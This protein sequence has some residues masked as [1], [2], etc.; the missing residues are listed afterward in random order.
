MSRKIA[1]S[2][3]DA[4]TIDI[5]NVI[6]S[7]S[8]LEY[9]TSVPA[10]TTLKDVPEVGMKI[11]G[12]PAFAN[13]YVNAL[14][15]RIAGVIVRSATFNDPFKLLKKGIIRYGETIEEV[16]VEMAKAREF[17]PEKA[18]QRELARVLPDIKAAFHVI[19][20]DVEIPMSIQNDDL[21]RA[22]TTEDGVLELIAKITDSIYRKVEY[23]EYNLFKYLLIKGYNNNEIYKYTIGSGLGVD[24]NHDA[25]IAFRALANRLTFITDKYNEAGVHTNTPREDLFIFM[26]A[27]YNAAF[28]V[29]VLSAAFNMDRADFM[30]KLILVDSFMEFDNDA[31]ADIRAGSDMIEVVTDEELLAMANVK[32]ILCDKE[33]FQVYQN[34]LASGF[35]ETY[36]STGRY[37]NYSYRDV[38]V[39]STSPFSNCVAVEAGS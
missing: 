22:F 15:N 6:R 33:Y 12:Y 36:V 11:L 37:W 14:V 8:N 38:K 31:F 35:A 1:Y 27:D 19:N 10:V 4:S 21:A 20:W 26:D 17:N 25:A 24:A 9:Q 28:D 5:F 34:D 16:F 32:A 29:G 3:L 2:T 18:T 13:Q 23:L 39:V 30:G 7:Q